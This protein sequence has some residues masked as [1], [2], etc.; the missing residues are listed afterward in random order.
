SRRRHT[1]F[2]RDWSSDVC[3]SDL[4]RHYTAA[5]SAPLPQRQ[6]EGVEQIAAY[7]EQQA[8]INRQ[9]PLQAIAQ[10][11]ALLHDCRRRQGTV[12]VAR[13]EERR[14]GKVKNAEVNAEVMR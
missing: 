8:A 10:A 5:A 11:A 13:S 9:M 12:Y 4:D 1:R 6:Q 14:V 2:S 3:S 7:W